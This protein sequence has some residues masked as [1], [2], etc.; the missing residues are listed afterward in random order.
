[1]N[2]GIFAGLGKKAVDPSVV[3]DLTNAGEDYLLRVGETAKIAYIGATSIPLCVATVE[4]VYEI[5]IIGD[6]IGMTSYSYTDVYLRPNNTLV[7]AGDINWSRMKQVGSTLNGSEITSSLTGF[8]ISNTPIDIYT[9][10]TVSTYTNNKFIRGT[11]ITKTAAD[12]TT[13][14]IHHQP[15]FNTTTIWSSLGTLDSGSTA[16]TGTIIIKRTV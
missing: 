3:I 2:E 10:A 14:L 8:I 16:H 5:E 6:G 9:K 4:G 13:Q 11:I 12:Q 7:T 15:W 1:M